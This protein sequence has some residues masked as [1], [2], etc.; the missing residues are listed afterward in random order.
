M[1]ILVESGSTKSTWVV[2]DDLGR[3]VSRTHTT[4]I[5]PF[6]QSVKDVGAIAREAALQFQAPTIEHIHFYGAGCSSEERCEQVADGLRNG[7]ANARINV[8]HD[9]M[10]AVRAAAG[11]N[12][13]IVAIM[14]TGSNS[15]AYDGQDIIDNVPALGYALGD[16]GSGSDLGRRLIQAW[17]Y[18][19]MDDSLSSAFESFSG[20]TKESM[21]QAVYHQPRPNK[22]L[23]SLAP[24]CDEHLT[25][26]VIN[27]LVTAAL[28][29]FVKRH[30]CKYE[31]AKS[32]PLH[33]VGS[34]AFAFRD[35]LQSIAE[36]NGLQLQQVIKHPVDSLIQYHV[37]N[38]V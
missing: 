12:P 34:I 14:G 29:S 11:N 23:A 4:G 1:Q 8:Q 3:E 17:I 6:F 18:R 13:A 35:P 26:P 36:A 20:L 28:T 19:E 38:E 31:H 27:E 25:H 37:A 33:I 2:I 32:W 30:L 10:A 16:E 7:F 24:F 21:L 22:F 15:C 9:M 5:N